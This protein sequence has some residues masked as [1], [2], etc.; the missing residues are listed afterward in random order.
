VKKYPTDLTDS[1]WN[2]IKDLFPQLKAMGRPREIKFRE[3]VNAINY[4]LFI[5][6]QWRFIPNDYPPWQTVYGY[7]REW[8]E[9][10]D[11]RNIAVRFATQ[12]RTP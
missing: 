11:A 10:S 4:L 1:Q 3:V 2:Q 5:G 7:F 9:L 12:E 8:E 6:C